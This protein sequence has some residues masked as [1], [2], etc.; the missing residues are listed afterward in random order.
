MGAVFSR[1]I[2]ARWRSLRYVSFAVAHPVVLETFAVLGLSLAAGMSFYSTFARCGLGALT[3]G[4]LALP[5]DSSALPPSRNHVKLHRKQAE[6]VEH[7]H[8]VLWS[9]AVK[10]CG[11]AT[12]EQ[13]VV[14]GG[15]GFLGRRIVHALLLRGETKVRVVDMDDKGLAAMRDP[16]VE[17]VR[18]DVTQRSQADAFLKGADVVFAPV[19]SIRY[20]EWEHKHYE[21]SASV[22][23][24]GARVLTE[25]CAAAGVKRLVAT[26]TA[27][28]VNAFP[29]IMP[30]GVDERT[31][32]TDWAASC[33]NYASSKA[34]GE[35]IYLAANGKQGM[36]VGVCR[37][38]TQIYGFNDK[39]YFDRAMQTSTFFVLNGNLRTDYVH[40]DHVVLAELLLEAR[41]RN[42]PAD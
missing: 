16:R 11:P 2:F 14:V 7:E 8:D 23:V 41:L 36:A 19:A 12:G 35:R 1:G 33:S 21:R 37:P 6:I 39:S 30:K 4:Y 22:N 27:T 25:A 24:T 13:Y 9:E 17:V 32:T 42:G 18:G 34:H 5:W 20:W 29:A 31:P 10:P 26:S 28:V 38:C 3:L 40:V 15:A